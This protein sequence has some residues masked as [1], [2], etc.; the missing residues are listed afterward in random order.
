MGGNSKLGKGNSLYIVYM[1]EVLHMDSWLVFLWLTTLWYSLGHLLSSFI[2]RNL[3]LSTVV[4]NYFFSSNNSLFKC[5]NKVTCI[6][7]D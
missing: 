5:I 4:L 7:D 3:E 1:S 2:S 6:A